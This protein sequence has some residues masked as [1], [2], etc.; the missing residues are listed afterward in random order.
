MLP[1]VGR[2]SIPWTDNEDK[3]GCRGPEPVCQRV[4]REKSFA[5]EIDTQKRVRYGTGL[6]KAQ[7][8]QLELTRGKRA[9]GKTYVDL[10]AAD[11]VVVKAGLVLGFREAVLRSPARARYRREL[12]E[13]D[14]PRRV[15]AVEPVRSW[16]SSRQT[17]LPTR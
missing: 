15:A 1:A 7:D 3:T 12:G 4:Q 16:P 14:R 10:K 6:K 9:Q 11:L 17:S 2:R 13:R 8:F 5:D